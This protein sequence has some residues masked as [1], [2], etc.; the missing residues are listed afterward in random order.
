MKI[1]NLPQMIRNAGRFREVVTI[2]V[3]YGIASWMKN[4]PIGWIERLF[5]TQDGAVIAQQSFEVRVR[6]AIQE[7]GTT[8]IKLGQILSTR[9]DIVGADLADEL[10]KLQANSP[11]DSPESVRATLFDEFGKPPDEIFESFEETAFASGSI[12]QVHHAVRDK[13][14]VV[15]KVLH[16]GI[17]R[18]V[19][20]D[21]DIIRELARLAESYSD[22]LRQYRPI[23]TAEYF[24][25]V[26]L[27]ELDFTRERENLTMFSRNFASD[28]QVRFPACF[29]EVCSRT[30]LTME[31]FR[32]PTLNQIRLGE[33]VSGDPADLA[34]RGA[35][36]FLNMLF[37]DRFFHADP[38]PGNL[39]VLDDGAIGI[40]D[41]GMVGSIDE[42]LTEHLEDLLLAS[43]SK[44][45]EGLLNTVTMIGDLPEDCDRNLLR[46]DIFEFV[47]RYGSQPVQSFDLSGALRQMVSVI[48]RH[49]IVLPEQ[50][51][52]LIKTLIIL[53]GTAR[54]LNP[55]F[56]LAELIAGYS[57]Q[58]TKRR[59]SFPR[60]WR[61]F[62]AAQ[63]D[64]S[65]LARM[66][67]G[68]VTDIMHRFK[69]GQF[70][71]HLDHRRLD[72]ITNRLVAGVLSAALFVGSSF[73]YGQRVPPCWG[74]YSLPGLLG[75]FAGV[76]LGYRVLRAIRSS[77]DL[78]E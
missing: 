72:S 65:R 53:E 57:W 78:K 6:E 4:V 74:D 13:Q 73:L 71:V 42:E 17:A 40:I 69:Q 60:F 18:R 75:C 70:D 39:M 48:H 8:F 16:T 14:P 28:P 68:D 37:R 46:S 11:A 22:V 67:P 1:A 43:I 45:A 23:R 29:D 38:H 7:L 20:N 56:S 9:P 26:L 77:G 32:G 21:I 27:A 49:R 33:K 62:L 36:V 61:K 24:S 52:M 76:L 41:A 3:K 30:V 35:N 34:L 25:R 47:E 66:L 5:R 54:S 51:A 15:V 50:A 19:A 44:D 58:I 10:A 59:L 12:G 64:W 2:L 63:R 55:D 31:L